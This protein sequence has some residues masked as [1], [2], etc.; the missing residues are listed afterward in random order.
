M[1]ARL[2]VAVVSLISWFAVAA[3]LAARDSEIGAWRVW[4]STQGVV[5]IAGPRS[6]GRFVV[7]ARGRLYLLRSAT[8]RLSPYPSTGKAYAANR[9]LEPYIALAGSGQRWAAG[10]CSFPRD[11]VYAIVPAGRT[12]VLA[13]A[14]SGRVHRLADIRGVKT[15]NGIVFDTVGRFG[16]KLLVVGLTADGHGA[17]IS[18]DCRGKARTLTSTAPHLEGGMTVAPAAFGAF[19]GDLIAPDEL[20]GRLLALAPDGSVRDVATLG[21]PAG[22]DIGVESIGFVPSSDADAYLADR[23]SPGNANPGHDAILRLTAGA[24]RAA[25]VAPGDLLAQ[26]SKAADDHRGSL[27]GDV[28]RERSGDGTYRRA[29]GGVDRLRALIDPSAAPLRSRRSRPFPAE[30]AVA[31]CS[32]TTSCRTSRRAPPARTRRTGRGPPR[33]N[34]DV[35]MPTCPVRP[36]GRLPKQGSRPPHVP[37]R[38]GSEAVPSACTAWRA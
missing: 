37:Y 8:G 3:P 23:L 4:R 15:L 17:L 18:V 19:A 21:Q 27:R 20:D 31:P 16:H 22:G 24:L 14:P 7:A 26:R 11:T 28:Q 6:D 34:V 36:G 33:F 9:K 30:N 29:C 32:G 35:R 5:D 1:R 2:L 25:G 38:S 10:G 12:G 13:V